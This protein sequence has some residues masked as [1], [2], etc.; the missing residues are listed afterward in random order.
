MFNL[1]DITSAHPSLELLVRT[2]LKFGEL[3]PGVEAAIDR[4]LDG[5]VLTDREVRLMAI[6]QDAIANGD[7][8]PV[9]VS[10]QALQTSAIY[11]QETEASFFP[12]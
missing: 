3:S 9:R 11:L 6:L 5:N 2:A 8:K 7:V 4:V 1:T 12:E 10:N